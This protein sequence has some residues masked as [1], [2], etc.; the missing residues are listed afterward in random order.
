MAN[1]WFRL[2]SE[3]AHDPK[4]QRLSEL[5]QRRFVMLLC[6]RCGNDNVTLQD[7]DVTFQLRISNNDWLVTKRVLMEKNLIN[8]DNLPVA[9]EKRQFVSDT[10]APRVAKHRAKKKAECN[11]TVTPQIQNRTDTDTEHKKK[12]L[13]PG[14]DT[15][16]AKSYLFSLGVDSS[17]SS[18]WIALRNTK[19]AKV[20]KTAIDGL[21]DE[22][23][24][25]G[26]SLSNVLKECCSRGWTGFKA[27]WVAKETKANAPA[28]SFLER[29][30]EARQRGLEK[31][32]NR[33]VA[34]TNIFE[35]EFIEN[36]SS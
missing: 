3:F 24:K 19:K 16:D 30:G 26:M 8:N 35:G 28:K 36:H 11:V 5:D 22:A 13:S 1:P 34:Q 10:S 32:R 23:E 2:Y 15:F 6:L 18:D 21:A 9:W 12:K 29:D 27:D 4:I 17:V 20:T 25:S 31:F 33:S 14:V 7:E